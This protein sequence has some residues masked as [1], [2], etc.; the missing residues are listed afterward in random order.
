MK[1][2]ENG[3]DYD[4]V[5]AGGG[6]AGSTAG[7]L[8]AQK[9]YKVAIFEK[10]KFPREHVG[11]S[12]LPFC[13][14]I[15]EKLGVLEQMKN[16]FVRKPGACF[17]SADGSVETTYCFKNVVEGDAYLSFHVRRAEF[18][19]LL[20]ENSKKNGVHVFE[21]AKIGN[22]TLGNEEEIISFN[23]QVIDKEKQ[24][25]RT[26]FFLDATGRDTLLA[27]QNKWRRPMKGLDRIAFHAHWAVKEIPEELNSGM[28]RINYL[29]GKD[30]KGWIWTIP[31]DKDSISVGVVLNNNYT[32]RQK[33]KIAK[34]N[35]QDW[36]KAIYMQELEHSLIVKSMIDSAKRVTPIWPNGDY[37]YYSEKKFGD[38][39]AMIGDSGQFI[40][41][42]F[43]SGVFIAIKTSQLVADAVDEKLSGKNKESLSKVFKIIKNGYDTVGELINVY[44]HPELFNFATF[45]DEESR[46][47]DFKS[48]YTLLHYLLAGDFFERGHIYAKFFR[49]LRDQKKFSRWQNLAKW[50]TEESGVFY[51]KFE[52]CNENFKSIFGEIQ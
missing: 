10:E 8:L 41:P 5:I 9:G 46:F 34:K 52:S 48:A 26:R 2:Y 17:A 32:K 28:V 37:S 11:E 45:S 39:F 23:V 22:V 4:I 21:Q 14:P 20:L 1:D 19:Q 12:L 51:G 35:I 31:L 18:D 33:K 25:I 3:I 13:Y 44:Y 24:T 36:V 50:D 15:F 7:T 30:K 29:E 42:V 47:G 27:K 6:P 40:D 43:S 38:N 49:E 16:K